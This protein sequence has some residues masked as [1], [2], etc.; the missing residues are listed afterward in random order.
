MND[1]SIGNRMYELAKKIFP[2]CRSI[3]GKGVRETIK[4]LNEYILQNT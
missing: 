2:Y 4:D 1:L 3:T